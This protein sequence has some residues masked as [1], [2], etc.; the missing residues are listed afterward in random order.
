MR[1]LYRVKNLTKIYKKKE[2]FKNLDLEIKNDEITVILGKSGCGKTTLMRILSKL[3]EDIQ[4][5]VKFYDENNLEAQ[6]KYGVVFQESRLL[7]WLTVEENITIHG[8]KE[9]VDK[10]LEMIGLGEY[11][12]SYPQ[13]L[14]GGMA[15]RVALARAL[16]YEPDTLFMDEPFSALDYFTRRQLQKELLKIYEKTKIG[17][18]FVT[19]NL[20][21]ALA[22]A[23]RVLVIKEGKIIEFRIDKNYPREI[24]DME[25]IKLKGKIID[26]IEN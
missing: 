23:H 16:S 10:Y 19:H 3:D 13:E 15:Q 18:I 9:N 24:E 14:S 25:L 26:L 22:L 8:R 7:P 4:G 20:D 5:E 12:K 6:G 21:E 1:G 17:I 2:V 11:R